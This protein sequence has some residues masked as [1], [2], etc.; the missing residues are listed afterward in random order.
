MVQAKF[1]SSQV[2]RGDTHG[3]AKKFWPD[4]LVGFDLLSAK[5]HPL[6]FCDV[7]KELRI[8]IGWR[9]AFSERNCLPVTVTLYGLSGGIRWASY[10]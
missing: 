9:N 8:A 10:L 2:L 7:W 1:P 3:F 5:Q 4:I 6:L